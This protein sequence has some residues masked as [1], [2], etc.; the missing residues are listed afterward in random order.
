[1]S[2]SRGFQSGVEVL[3]SPGNF[4]PAITQLT[5]MWQGILGHDAVVDRFRAT[6]RRGRLASTYL[7][8]GPAGVGKRRFALAL[9]KALLC[10]EAGDDPLEPCGICESCR[11][12]DAGNHPDLDVVSLPPDRSAL[13]V[14]LF[15]G[16]KDHRNR[17]GLCHRLAL[18]PYLGGRK[19]AIIDDADRFNQESANCLLKTLE[20]PP[21]RS[22]VILI[23]TSASRQLPT[24]RSRAQV[25]RFQPLAL[26]TVANVLLDQ[27]IVDRR[28]EA[29]RLAIFSEGSIE[30]ARQ[31][32]ERTMWEFRQ[33]LLPQ[34]SANSLDCVRLARSIQAFV[35]GAG[36]E[37]TAR[38]ERLRIAIMFVEEFLGELQR[39]R[40]GLSPQGDDPLR[41]AVRAANERQTQ[42]STYAVLNAS[43]SCLVA[44]EN[45]DRNANLALLIQKWCEDLAGLNPANVWRS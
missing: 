40:A 1:V 15:I 34:F 24:I 38:R 44:V 45:V 36:K 25:L 28:D 5:T 20:E 35:D 31:L 22:L 29:T 14:E 41:E 10:T 19:I 12:F 8:V 11:L 27:K 2:Q 3:Q 37:A 9:A 6:L 18:K 42:A 32:A 39:T 4:E 16:D 33:Q 43:D 21:P 17:D 23:G 30:R 7:F 13:P 26:E